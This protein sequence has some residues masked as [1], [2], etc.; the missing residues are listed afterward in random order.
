VHV[1]GLIIALGILVL[2]LLPAS[3]QYFARSR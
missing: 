1:V 3:K 2:L